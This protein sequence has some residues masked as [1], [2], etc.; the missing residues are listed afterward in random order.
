MRF[1]Q[2]LLVSALASSVFAQNDIPLSPPLQQI[3]ADKNLPQYQ[4]P[5]QLTQNIVPKAF[6]SH[7]DYWRELPFWSALSYGA[8]SVEADVW[9]YN[10][11]LHIGHEPSAL[12]NERTLQ[13][14]YINPILQAINAQ[15]PSTGF[16][17]GTKNGVFDTASTQ[18]L[19]LWI[20]VKT[21]GPSTW[22]VVVKALDPL[23]QRGLLTSVNGSTVTPGAITVIG[24]GNTPLNQ[25]QNLTAR[26]YFY[27]APLASL[28]SKTY[29]NITSLISP[30]ASAQFSAVFGPVTTE[31]LN[32]TQLETLK[33]QVNG[34]KNKG[35]KTR[36]WDQPGWPIITRNT[37]WRQLLDNGVDLLNV[38]DLHGAANFWQGENA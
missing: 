16:A 27:D 29:A 11:A 14:L 32:G 34:A 17:S 37:V 4:Y 5:T 12:T 8:V 1:H 35:I 19:Y 23:R 21:D 31:G 25:I 22:P 20:D 3:L 24:T 36:Y 2:A 38:D 18:T 10:G 30:I 9:N 7:N 6:H 15:N 33:G 26:D 28:S 13:S